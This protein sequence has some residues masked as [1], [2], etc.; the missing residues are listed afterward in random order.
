LFLNVIFEQIND[1][2]DRDICNYKKVISIFIPVFDR[3][4]GYYAQD[5]TLT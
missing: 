3:H 2:D 5:G 1:D 4:V